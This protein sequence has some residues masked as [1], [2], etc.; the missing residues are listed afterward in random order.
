L[1]GFSNIKKEQKMKT[2]IAVIA[3]CLV[4][5][6]PVFGKDKP[7]YEVGIFQTSVQVND[8]SYGSTNGEYSEAHN[9]SHNVHVLSTPEGLYYVHAPTAVAASMVVGIMTGGH[10]E[11]FHK[12]WFMDDLHEGDKVL[13]SAECDKHNNCKFRLPN[14]E[15]PDKV[16]STNGNFKPLNAKT[17]IDNSTKLCG[18][19][20]LSPEAEAQ[21]CGKK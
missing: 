17:N 1:T 11:T 19:G 9:A 2:I 3:I 5:F 13:F 12:Q 10:S 14:P 4:V 8:G 21:I 7:A 18:T 20:K 6:I 16:I 15:T